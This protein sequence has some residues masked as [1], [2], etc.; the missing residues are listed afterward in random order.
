MGF[1]N[2]G[3]DDDDDDDDGS[4]SDSSDEDEDEQE[5]IMMVYENGQAVPP[6][7]TPASAR[8]QV[9]AL[10]RPQGGPPSSLAGSAIQESEDVF[11]G[12]NGS[13]PLPPAEA[14]PAA[15]EQPTAAMVFRDENADP[16]MASKT[17][18]RTPLSSRKPTFGVLTD[19]REDESKAAVPQ[20]PAFE[21]APAPV[22][23]QNQNVFSTPM[24]AKQPFRRPAPLGSFAEEAEEAE[25]GDADEGDLDDAERRRREELEEDAE[26]EASYRS[27]RG[28]WEGRVGAFELM[29]PI[30][31]RTGEW[32]AHGRSSMGARSSIAPTDFGIAE[33]EEDTTDADQAFH[34]ATTNFRGFSQSPVTAGTTGKDETLPSFMEGHTGRSMP[35]S[36][37]DRSSSTPFALSE[38]YTIEG[39]TGRTDGM[40][41]TLQIVDRTS[42]M[43][44]DPLDEESTVTNTDLAPAAQAAPGMVKVSNPCNPQETD[45]IWAVLATLDPPAAFVP[46]FQ[47]LSSTPINR[48]DGLQKAAKAR[49]R[50]G[51]TGSAKSGKS[52]KTS[53]DAASPFGSIELGG[54]EYEVREKIGEGGFGA[55]FLAR[56]VA[57]FEAAAQ[58]AEDDDDEDDDGSDADSDD[59]GEAKHLVALKVERPSSVWEGVVLARIHNRLPADLTRSII[60]SRGLYT[61][62]DESYLVLDYASQGTVLD[63]VNQAGRIGI[64]PSAQG[65]SGMD[66]LVVMFFAVELMK[67]VE[68]LHRA[69]FIHGD[70]K[71][72]NCLVRLN[73]ID[74][75][76]WAGQYDAGGANGWASKGVRII[77]FG[78]A[79]DM[80]LFPDGQ[81]FIADWAVDQRDCAEM[82]EAR[83]WSYQAD[84]H[85][86]ASVF[87]CML[88]GAPAA[89]P[90]SA[91]SFHVRGR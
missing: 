43:R 24:P 15:D 10:K 36:D 25:E 84:Y 91:F 63:A 76:A 9:F 7:P 38:G 50:R 80:S 2:A 40:L 26:D 6:T 85:G 90:S 42:S 69:G 47:D 14:A 3:A 71:I 22:P 29:T 28:A 53:L 33:E 23:N 27:Q 11:A 55:V 79:I 89:P 17:P 39:N 54:R 58:K 75:A 8:G 81:T 77:D 20:Q 78:R 86:L 35:E 82:R 64:A 16:A 45:V 46:G 31:E 44:L 87:Y 61:F 30:T 52:G 32:S 18:S 60:A 70:L 48:L 56:D 68:G 74:N 37:F 72:D 65:A 57:S 67:I 1:F 21:P 41:D 62:A 19:S 5:P 66:E 49:Q 73:S 34:T 12:G 83:P 88:F 59:D 51:S 4:D 13:P